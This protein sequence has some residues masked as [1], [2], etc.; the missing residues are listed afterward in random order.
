MMNRLFAFMLMSTFCMMFL[1]C[2]PYPPAVDSESDAIF[3][4]PHQPPMVT[5][6]IT[7]TV[8]YE[9]NLV[10]VFDAINIPKQPCSQI[11]SDIDC[12]VWAIKYPKYLQDPEDL[13]NSEYLGVTQ[14][15]IVMTDPYH[16][17]YKTKNPYRFWAVPEDKSW[18]SLI[19]PSIGRTQRSK[20][21]YDYITV[22]NNPN[23]DYKKNSEVIGHIGFV[24]EQS[25]VFVLEIK[26]VSCCGSTPPGVGLP[27]NP[28]SGM[29]VPCGESLR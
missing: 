8:T 5:Q 24:D 20:D 27:P 13:D 16:Y 2:G 25:N 28:L 23:F 12:S 19:T 10:E 17:D 26:G 7:T 15:R 29:C 18:S 1:S 9:D 3:N 22:S 14:I 4:F 6:S 21:G 11:D